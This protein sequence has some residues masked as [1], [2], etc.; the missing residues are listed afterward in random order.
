MRRAA[1]RIVLIAFGILA[2]G[3]FA[4]DTETALRTWRDE[5]GKFE[6]H[7]RFVRVEGGEVILQDENG[8]EIRVPR[9]RL[10]V[11]DR[12]WLGSQSNSG[13][14]QTPSGEV[15]EVSLGDSIGWNLKPDPLALVPNEPKPIYLPFDVTGL[16]ENEIGAQIAT[17][18]DGSWVLASVNENGCLS[19]GFTDAP[20]KMVKVD[21]SSHHVALTPNGRFLLQHGGASSWLEIVDLQA[22]TTKPLHVLKTDHRAEKTESHRTG[23]VFSDFADDDFV[24]SASKD[25]VVVAWSVENG[26]AIWWAGNC[27]SVPAISPGGKYVVVVIDRKLVAIEI[28]SGQVAAQLDVGQAPIERLVICPSGNH[29][30]GRVAGATHI[31]EFANGT[32]IAEFSDGSTWNNVSW[33]WIDDRYYVHGSND[34]GGL[35][36]AEIGVDIWEFSVDE[37]ERL[38]VIPGFG[39]WVFSALPQLIVEPYRIP[40]DGFAEISKHASQSLVT[41]MGSD[42][43]IQ[44]IYETAGLPGFLDSEIRRRVPQVLRDKG[45]SISANSSYVLRL[46]TTARTEQINEQAIVRLTMFAEIRDANEEQVWTH[47]FPLVSLD[48]SSDDAAYEWLTFPKSIHRV[49]AGVRSWG[50]RAGYHERRSVLLD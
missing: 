27:T 8:R 45:I 18:R 30:S 10:S 17:S 33:Q 15:I 43:P 42:H 2:H 3:L 40:T 46:K 31:W 49:N 50:F 38:A 37:T 9:Q 41:M 25:G 39:V 16:D 14:E 28:G 32:E 12:R 5:T 1:S 26:Q 11:D 20:P 13:A 19:N 47:Q 6:V 24:I 29:I 22:D 34:F 44:V 36:D 35:V 21:D 23:L 4:Q 48:Q 7:A